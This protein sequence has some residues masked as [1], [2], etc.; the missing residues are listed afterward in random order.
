MN[1][2]HEEEV[3]KV[4]PVDSDISCDFYF[5]KVAKERLWHIDVINYEK[6]RM[7]CL[8][9]GLFKLK[10]WESAYNKLKAMNKLLILM[11]F[12]SG[13]EYIPTEK[14]CNYII[15][16]GYHLEYDTINEKYC[17]THY[18]RFIGKEFLRKSFTLSSWLSSDINYANFYSDSCN[19]KGLLMNHIGFNNLKVIR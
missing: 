8:G 12:I 6:K 7:D 4:Y 16:Q 17:I 3:R 9:K 18:D 11:L 15:P 10:A 19:A 14:K 2:N 13:C 1:I 5:D